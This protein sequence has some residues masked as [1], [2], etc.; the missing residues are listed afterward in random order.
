MLLAQYPGDSLIHLHL[1]TDEKEVVLELGD[2]KVELQDE[3]IDEVMRDFG[4]K[5]LRY[6]LN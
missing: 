2:Y 6:S 4:E 5:S 1:L 3:F